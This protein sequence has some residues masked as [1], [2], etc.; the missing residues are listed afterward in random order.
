M[1]E[2]IRENDKE[3]NDILVGFE[4]IGYK[5]ISKDY[6]ESVELKNEESGYWKEITIW[7]DVDAIDIDVYVENMTLNEFVLLEK[8]FKNITLENQR[9]KDYW[10]E[11]DWTETPDIDELRKMLKEQ[12]NEN[13]R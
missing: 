4:T 11:V 10:S 1:R 7:F 12:D 9:L 3:L 6:T 5:S 13:N 2:I 8:L